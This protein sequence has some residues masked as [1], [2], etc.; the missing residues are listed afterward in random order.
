MALILKILPESQRGTL[1]EQLGA[2][3]AEQQDAFISTFSKRLGVD[4][5]EL[6]RSDSEENDK[7]EKEESDAKEGVRNAPIPA[8]KTISG[9]SMGIIMGF[10]HPREWGQNASI[11]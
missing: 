1:R 8:Y 2:L 10:L 7:Q 11:V 9:D 5:D 3:S 4:I 6:T